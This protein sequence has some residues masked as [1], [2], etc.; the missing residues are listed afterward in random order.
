MSPS[1]SLYHPINSTA[2][3]VQHHPSRFPPPLPRSHCYAFS[4][5]RRSKVNKSP[6]RPLTSLFLFFPRL[7]TP[8]FASWAGLPRAGAMQRLVGVPQRPFLQSARQMIC[9][10]SFPPSY[11]LSSLQSHKSI[12]K[13]TIANSRPEKLLPC[14]V[15]RW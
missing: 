13:K 1:S 15:F 2:N 14:D 12:E 6:D 10:F 8:I 11:S 3:N 7:A 5:K 4:P 9:S